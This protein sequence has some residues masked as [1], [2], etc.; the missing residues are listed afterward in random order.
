M[1]DLATL[2]KKMPC[3]SSVARAGVVRVPAAVR[4][5]VSSLPTRCCNRA[6]S[7]ANV[8]NTSRTA[9]A[10]TEKEDLV[11]LLPYGALTSKPYAFQARP[12]ELRH[13]ESIDVSDGLGS[14]IRVDFKVQYSDNLRTYSP[15][16]LRSKPSWCVF[17]MWSRVLTLQY[18]T[19]L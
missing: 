5:S 2:A 15:T 12:W 7:T 9:V 19:Q 14:N 13:A 4:V 1:Q 10:T 17:L 8:E 16:C 6:I 11:P 3:I 18:T